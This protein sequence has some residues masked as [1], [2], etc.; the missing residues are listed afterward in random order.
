MKLFPQSEEWV[1]NELIDSTTLN[2]TKQ[3][4]FLNKIII[5]ESEPFQYYS[6]KEL[7]DGFNMFLTIPNL[8]DVYHE[9]DCDLDIWYNEIKSIIK[10]GELFFKSGLFFKLE[11]SCYDICALLLICKK[12]KEE[13]IIN[14]ENPKDFIKNTLFEL[15]NSILIEEG[16]D[17]PSIADFFSYGNVLNDKL[18]IDYYFLQDYNNLI[19]DNNTN[20]SLSLLLNGGKYSYLFLSEEYKKLIYDGTNQDSLNQL[21]GYII[22]NIDFKKDLFKYNPEALS[23]RYEWCSDRETVILAVTSNGLSLEYANEQFKEDNYI[24]LQAVKN[25]YLAFQDCSELLRSD[26]EFIYEAYKLND[27][28]IRFIDDKTINH[29]KKIQD[30]YNEYKT[31]DE[32]T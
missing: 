31:R 5:K 20:F 32:E 17:Y 1:L 29:Y 6:F 23:Y 8:D 25:N 14:V 12:L 27:N 3:L 22:N 21:D 13:K 19:L 26:E 9:S 28:I 11:I 15:D 4:N 18:M 24:A 16:L 2:I 30:L 7:M 10:A